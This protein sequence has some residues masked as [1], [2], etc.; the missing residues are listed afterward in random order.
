M[1]R[2]RESCPHLTP[3][4]IFNPPAILSQSIIETFVNWRSQDWLQNLVPN[5]GI[6]LVSILTSIVCYQEAATVCA[7][8]SVWTFP[9]SY[10]HG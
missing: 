7:G 6:S 5:L 8:E 9:G 2:R 10:S 1:R 4:N 3:I